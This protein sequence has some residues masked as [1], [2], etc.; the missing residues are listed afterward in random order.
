MMGQTQQQRG[1]AYVKVPQ[2]PGKGAVTETKRQAG[3][4]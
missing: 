1:V 2:Q 3:L 4:T